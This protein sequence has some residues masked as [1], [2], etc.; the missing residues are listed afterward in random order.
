[1]YILHC[2]CI[3]IIGIVYHYS[4]YMYLYYYVQHDRQYMIVW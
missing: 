3:R 2:M 1:M 4:M